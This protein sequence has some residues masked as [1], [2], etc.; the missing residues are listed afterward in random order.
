MI[1]Y[2]TDLTG[3]IASDLAGLNKNCGNDSVGQKQ[4][5]SVGE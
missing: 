1:E 4:P 2:R 5:N 3:V